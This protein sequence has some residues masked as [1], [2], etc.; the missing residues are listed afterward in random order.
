MCRIV[1]D[2]VCLERICSLRASRCPLMP[3]LVGMLWACHVPGV[4]L[5]VLGYQVSAAA[6]I[7]R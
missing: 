5:L 6:D 7:Y 4:S 1:P 3:R 2:L